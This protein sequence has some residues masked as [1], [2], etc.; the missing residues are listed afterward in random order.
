MRADVGDCYCE[1]YWSRQA[2]YVY[3]DFTQVKKSPKSQI[4]RKSG[5]M[6]LHAS[7]LTNNRL[8]VSNQQV[9]GP[10]AMKNIW[11]VCVKVL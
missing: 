3:I 6:V 11:S 7:K 5:F 1:R 2:N 10:F 9:D 8:L 4:P